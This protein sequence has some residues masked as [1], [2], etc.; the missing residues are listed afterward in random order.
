MRIYWHKMLFDDKVLYMNN[1]SDLF[2]ATCIAMPYDDDNDANCVCVCLKQKMVIKWGLISITWTIN[3]TDEKRQDGK[4]RLFQYWQ[5][6]VMISR[7][8]A[9][10]EKA[11]DWHR[12]ESL[13]SIELMFCSLWFIF[14]RRQRGADRIKSQR[15]WNNN[16]DKIPAI[17][18]VF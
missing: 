16:A 6:M 12:H 9:N 8:S 14:V 13:P 1:S 11:R 18:D 5:I 3:S 10:H 7:V 4:H 17:W 15:M 2:W